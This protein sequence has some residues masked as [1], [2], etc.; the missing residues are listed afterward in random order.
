ME[1]DLEHTS[2]SGVQA[3]ISF[4]RSNPV[5][6]FYILSFFLVLRFF[7]N[8]YA[9]PLRH[10][11]GPFLASG[12]RVWKLWVTWQTH[13]ETEYINLH[14]KYGP[15]VRVAPNELSFSR[16]T[17]AREILSA[18]KGFHKTPFY[19]VFPPPENPD[20]FTETREHVHAAKKRVAGTSYSMASM[21]GMTPYIEDTIALLFAKLDGFATAG[22]GG[23]RQEMDLGDWLHYFAFDVLGEVAFG[24]K[25]GFLA[26]GRDVEGCINAIDKSQQ[27]NGTVGQL[28]ALDL[29]LRRNP[30]WRA[31]QKLYPGAQP[32]VTRIALEELRKRRSGGA[33]T[34]RKDLLGQLL[35]ANEAFPDRFGEGDVFAVTHGAIF[36]GSDSTASTMQSFMHHVLRDRRIY[37]ALLAEIDNAAARGALSPVVAFNEAQQ[38]PLFQAA[39][40]EAMRV[41]PAVG[42]A[43]ARS[44]PPGGAEIDGAR[45]P[46]GT[47][48]NINAWAVHRDQEMFGADA[49]AF[50][51]E[52]WLEDGERARLMDRHMLQFGGGSHVCIGRNLALL[53]MNKVLPM[54]LRDY[55][56]ELVHPD[57]ELDFHTYFFVVQKGLNVRI[58]KRV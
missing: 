57:R 28:P 11:P 53:E 6:I 52:R 30:L 58:S 15:V 24:K 35:K 10:Y 43:M 12:T 20:I 31:A 49:E 2:G 16:P 5:Y 21:Q 38:L 17:A 40:K 7:K 8:R 55:A 3:A 22:G 4:L 27:Y 36:A 50:R 44:V 46:G 26:E 29:L 34:E 33:T 39:L 32:L 47:G 18:G 1:V 45:Y 51:P 9:S 14:K 54:L 56:L 42:L 48:L 13:Q 41:R 25:W 19:A 37:A 23:G